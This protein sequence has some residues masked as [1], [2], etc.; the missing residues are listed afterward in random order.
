MEEELQQQI[1]ILAKAIKQKL[2]NTLEIKIDII[3]RLPLNEADYCLTKELITLGVSTKALTVG[4]GL[5]YRDRLDAAY[6]LSEDNDPGRRAYES[7]ETSV[8][9]TSGPPRTYV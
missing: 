9:S 6:V 4:E 5:V 3:S 8:V 1:R 2:V 7:P